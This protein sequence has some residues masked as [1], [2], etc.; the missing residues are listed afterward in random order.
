MCHDYMTILVVSIKNIDY[1]NNNR[2][3]AQGILFVALY[4]IFEVSI[5]SIMIQKLNTKFEVSRSTVYFK[6][7][8]R[9]NNCRG[10]AIT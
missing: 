6:E 7:L 1:K 9:Q 10:E 8:Q 4:D 5:S 2:L 3:L